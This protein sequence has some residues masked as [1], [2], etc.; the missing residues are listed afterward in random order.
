MCAKSLPS[1][2]LSPC[3]LQPARFLC[4]R[5][6]KGENTGVGCYALLQ[7]ILPTQ[8]LNPRL[9]GLLHWQAGSLPLAPPVSM[10]VNKF[11]LMSVSKKQ[12]FES[13]PSYK[14]LTSGLG[15]NIMFYMSFKSHLRSYS[16]IRKVLICKTV[17]LY[18]C[19]ILELNSEESKYAHVQNSNYKLFAFLILT[20]RM[21]WQNIRWKKCLQRAFAVL[22]LKMMFK[23]K[24][25]PMYCLHMKNSTDTLERNYQILIE[26]RLYHLDSEI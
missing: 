6:S 4:P 9:S 24:Y 14:K 21:D 11:T 17:R 13:A 2:L 20:C 26:F 25:A 22:Q 16:I 10:I 23:N 19:R 12:L 15:L 18:L 1:C 7:G 5:D 8:A 3:G